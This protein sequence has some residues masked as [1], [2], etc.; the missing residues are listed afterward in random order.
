MSLL[1]WEALLKTCSFREEG[2]YPIAAYS[3]FMPPVR[4]G[5]R[6]Y[7]AKQDGFFRE[8]N[9]WGFPVTEFEEAL[10]MRP[11]C[12]MLPTRY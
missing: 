11:A 5:C 12:K 8:E 4:V 9:P 1:G 10:E 3:E 6:P 2:Q 7:D